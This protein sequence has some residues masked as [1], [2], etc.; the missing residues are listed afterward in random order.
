M[1]ANLYVTILENYLLPFIR[2]EYVCVCVCVC[3]CVCVCVCARVCVTTSH[4]MCKVC[5]CTIDVVMLFVT[6]GF[7][8]AS[9]EPNSNCRKEKVRKLRNVSTATLYM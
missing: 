3:M 6:K 7:R 5:N 1:D 9:W 2:T 4:T 8:G